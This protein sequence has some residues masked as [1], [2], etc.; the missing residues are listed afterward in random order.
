ME[1]PRARLHCIVGGNIGTSAAGLF[2]TAATNS[3]SSVKAPIYVAALLGL[4]SRLLKA[5]VPRESDDAMNQKPLCG[6]GFTRA[7]GRGCV[8]TRL[9]WVLNAEADLQTVQVRQQWPSSAA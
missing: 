8:E 3:N 6:F 7:S 1:A 9:A 4:I 5:E 2:I